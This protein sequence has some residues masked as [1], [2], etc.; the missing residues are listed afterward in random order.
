MNK[1]T[2]HLDEWPHNYSDKLIDNYGR[3]ISY[4]RI[5]VTDRCNLH[6]QYCMPAEGISFQGHGAILSY[7][8]ILRLLDIAA[9]LGI[10]K[11]RFTG[12]E[13]FVRKNFIHLFEKADFILPLCQV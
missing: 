12:G 8:E 1:Q 5:A 9:S 7:E 13:P 3:H 6:C 10:T 2:E 11:I 4:L